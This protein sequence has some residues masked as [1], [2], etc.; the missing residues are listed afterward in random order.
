M[1]CGPRAFGGPAPTLFYFFLNFLFPV[2]SRSTISALVRDPKEPIQVPRKTQGPKRFSLFPVSARDPK[3]PKVPRKRQAPKFKNR[4]RNE[5][6]P[7]RFFVPCFSAGSKQRGAPKSPRPQKRSS[8]ERP[9]RPQ[10]SETTN[11]FFCSF[12]GQGAPKSEVKKIIYRVGQKNVRL[13][14]MLQNQN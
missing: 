2:L 13:F 4:S 1:C 14:E 6:G 9:V 12:F 10:K 7:K 8:K 3:E 5:W 11:K